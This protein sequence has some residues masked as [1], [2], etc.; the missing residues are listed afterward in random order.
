[1]NTRPSRS[2]ARVWMAWSVKPSQPLPWCAPAL[3]CSTLSTALSSSTP[4]RAQG[5]RQPWSGRG[6]PSSCPI[7]LKMLSS[8]GGTGTPGSTEKHR[9]WAWPGPWYGSWPRITTLTWSNGVASNAANRRGP[10]GYT[11]TPS[12]LRWRRKR[13][14]SRISGRSSQSPMRAFQDGSRRMADS[15]DM[16]VPGMRSGWPPSRDGRRRL[17]AFQPGQAQLEQDLGHQ[18]ALLDRLLHQVVGA[19]AQQPGLVVPVGVTGH[20]Q[21]RQAALAVVEIHADALDHVAPAQLA[22][23]G[24]V[25]QDQVDAR[26]AAQGFGGE[27]G[28]RLLGGQHVQ[29]VQL[30]ALEHALGG[31]GHH[32]AVLDVQ[33]P[34]AGDRLGL[35]VAADEFRQRLVA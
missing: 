30:L 19:G 18:Q 2:L 32:P 24:D 6:R 1:M 8:D 35:H 33:H 20:H 34:R 7:S 22:L 17:A 10:G 14:S 12:A 21:H 28:E 15:S 29:H 26:H 16:A 9:P 25:G 3:P 31:L 4:R 11:L 23:E 5:S 27:Q 13:E